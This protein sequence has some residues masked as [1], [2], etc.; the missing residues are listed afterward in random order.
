MGAANLREYECT[1]RAATEPD[2]VI[3]EQKIA[4]CVTEVLVATRA[5]NEA[6]ERDKPPDREDERL[7]RPLHV[8]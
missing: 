6:Y 5:A 8:R 7:G 3:R 2:A 1:S 4:A